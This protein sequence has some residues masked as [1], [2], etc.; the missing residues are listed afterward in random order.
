VLVALA[1][2]IA[3]SM[4]AGPGYD[5]LADEPCTLPR[6]SV[7]HSLGLDSW[8]GDYPRP[9]AGLSAV[10]LF[11]SFPGV[12]P[13]A[14]PKAIAA[15]YFPATT[16]FFLRA[17][18]G[19]FRLSVEVGEDWVEMPRPAA[20]Y[21]IKRDWEPRLR[22][23]YLRDA[24][25]TL[26]SR[27][28]FGAYDV[29][30]LVADPDAPGVNSDATKVVN[31]DRPLQVGDSEIRRIVTIFESRPPD[32][33]VLAHE[34]GHVFDLPDLY[35]R[36]EAGNGDWDTHVGDW[37]VM[38]S[39]FGL[40][41]EPFGWHKWK[42]GWL[43]PAYVTCV[44]SESVSVHALQPLAAPLDPAGPKDD[45]RLVVVR[46]GADEALVLE[47]RTSAGN[48]AATCTEGVLLYR[49]R[50]DVASADGP[51]QV[52]DGHPGTA[53][54]H[55]RSV[56]PELADAPLGSGESYWLAEENIRVVVGGRTAAGGWHLKIVRE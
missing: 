46:T 11:L 47:A 9:D 34:T 22:S 29:V 53:A 44:R 24:V 25:E 3:T 35:N 45:T 51:I 4:T 32:R 18:Y 17:S 8:N 12:T 27:V 37:D 10:M 20:S 41:P 39:Q 21:E 50:S 33:N 38:G 56:Q 54:C 31:F 13:R 7:H 23:S 6:H 2:M 5:A 36:P 16:D 19:G 1:A 15:D 48:D 14:T 52:V 49:V 40:A 28:D 43:G 42:L 26:A 30:Y 55:G